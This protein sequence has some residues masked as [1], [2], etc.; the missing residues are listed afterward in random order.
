MNNKKKNNTHKAKQDE[1][2]WKEIAT[3]TAAYQHQ[4]DEEHEGKQKKNQFEID[5]CKR[6]LAIHLMKWNERETNLNDIL[7]TRHSE[8]NK[9]FPQK[10]FSP[11]F[12]QNCQQLS[13]NQKN[14]S[15]LW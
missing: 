13:L 1:R 6:Y 8:K 10:P 7:E 3:T 12:A 9:I 14:K 5:K 2:N 11:H 4:H 15:M